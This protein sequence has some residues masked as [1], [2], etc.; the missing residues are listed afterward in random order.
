MP[1]PTIATRARVTAGESFSP[2]SARYSARRR[3]TRFLISTAFSGRSRYLPRKPSASPVKTIAASSTSSG[4]RSLAIEKNWS[5]PMFVLKYFSSKISSRSAATASGSSRTPRRTFCRNELRNRKRREQT[6]NKSVVL[7]LSTGRAQRLG[8]DVQEELQLRAEHSRDG[9]HVILHDVGPVDSF[10]LDGEVV[11]VVPGG[12]PRRDAL[13]HLEVEAEEAPLPEQR[14]VVHGADLH[15]VEP[16]LQIALGQIRLH[17]EEELRLAREPFGLQ[18][19]NEKVVLEDEL[20]PREARGDDF[21]REQLD[22]VAEVEETGA[23]TVVVVE[24]HLQGPAPLVEDGEISEK[25]REL[26]LD[27]ERMH[28]RAPPERLENVDGAAEDLKLHQRPPARRPFRLEGP[29]SGG[30]LGQDEPM[31][32]L[33]P[34]RD[35]L[36]ECLERLGRPD[37]RH[38][39]N[40]VLRKDGEVLSLTRPLHDGERHALVAVPV[41]VP[42]EEAPVHEACLDGLA[43][44]PGVLVGHLEDLGGQEIGRAHV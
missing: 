4:R 19:R 17:R 39:W 26:A 24:R 33:E 5:P 30:L 34:V 1:T 36:A 13:E 16:L 15:R 44:R 27:R 41:L 40:E 18:V 28:G 25:A 29:A 37:L 14:N 22:V 8:D 11:V 38:R 42:E 3:Y 31:L 32:G 6:R 23:E 35:R 43:V 7:L 12:K 10:L 9:H 20:D 21:L 2:T